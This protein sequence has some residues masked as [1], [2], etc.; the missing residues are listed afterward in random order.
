MCLQ[1]NTVPQGLVD[2]NKCT[3]VYDAE[4]MTGHQ[5][6]IAVKTPE[7]QIYIKGTDKHEINR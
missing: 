5:L 3:D 4:N 7:K 1:I 6:S 2:M